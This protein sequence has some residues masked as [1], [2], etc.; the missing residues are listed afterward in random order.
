MERLQVLRRWLRRH[1]GSLRSLSL[2]T[3]GPTG[4]SAD[5]KALHAELGRCFAV[6]CGGGALRSLSISCLNRTQLRL[7]PELA[8][9]GDAGAPSLSRLS[10]SGGGGTLHLACPLQ[11]LTGLRHLELRGACKWD[12]LTQLPP[13]ITSLELDKVSADNHSRLPSQLVF[14][15]RLRYLKMDQFGANIPRDGYSVLTALSS[16]TSLELVGAPSWPVALEGL[17]SLQRL[18]LRSLSWWEGDAWAWQANLVDGGGPGALSLERTLRA[19]GP[20]LTALCLGGAMPRPLDPAGALEDSAR[21]RYLWDATRPCIFGPDAW[22]AC[23]KA[24]HTS[25]EAVLNGACGWEEHVG[26][27]LRMLSI[28]PRHGLG[29]LVAR[30]RDGWRAFWAWAARAPALRLLEIHGYKSRP[31][32]MVLANE[33]N[34]LKRRRPSLRIVTKR[35]A[36][37]QRHFEQRAGALL[38]LGGRAA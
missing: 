17:T 6:A 3:G 18:E 23:L 5:V 1:A 14:L 21:L 2:E 19:L 13:S 20:S 36:S 9:I 7:G 30:S 12:S 31:P 15:T 24:A 22:P 33:I 4:P 34:S 11:R 10:L 38:Q 26:E 29:S 32:E 25:W 28:S 16:L 8:V 27:Q 35:A 37:E